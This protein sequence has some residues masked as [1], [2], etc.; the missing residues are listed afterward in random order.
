ML[1]YINIVGIT[2]NI[3]TKK[4][5]RN[6][7]DKKSKTNCSFTID[8]QRNKQNLSFLKCYIN[9]LLQE[10]E[11]I[12][13]NEIFE[14]IRMD[15]IDEDNKEIRNCHV[16]LDRYSNLVYKNNSHPEY[17]GFYERTKEKK[18]KERHGWSKINIYDNNKQIKYNI[19]PEHQVFIEVMDVFEEYKYITYE[20]NNKLR[21]DM[22]KE[23][24][25]IREEILLNH[26]N[27][28]KNKSAE[29][30]KKLGYIINNL[31]NSH[32]DINKEIYD[33]FQDFLSKQ[34]NA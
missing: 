4:M 16:I 33:I 31:Y 30:K 24:S 9:E 12:I 15:Y 6:V 25:I 34:R 8:K 1:L 22:D 26:E 19:Y 21:D 20:E 13:L 7:T 28:D 14:V 23:I 10:H 18:N 3:M 11:N 27:K 29:I 2:Q 17:Y 32:Y 5:K